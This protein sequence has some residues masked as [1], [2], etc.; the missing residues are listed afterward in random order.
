MEGETQPVAGVEVPRKKKYVAPVI[1]LVVAAAAV[2]IMV[3]LVRSMMA[4]PAAPSGISTHQTLPADFKSDPAFF[5]DVTSAN[6]TVTIATGT[7]LVDLRTMET[8]GH[9]AKGSSVLVGG[10]WQNKYYLSLYSVNTKTP[11]GFLMSAAK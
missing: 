11:D 5:K 9:L 8:V 3:Y 2:A 7:D 1:V 4:L 6:L 10:T